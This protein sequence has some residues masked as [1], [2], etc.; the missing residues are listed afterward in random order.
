M[1]DSIQ[2]KIVTPDRVVLREEVERVVAPGSEGDFEVL[3]RHTPFLTSLK[4][5]QIFYSKNGK[6][7]VLSTS[8]GFVEVRMDRMTILAET[9]EWPQEIDRERAEA[10]RRRA[11]RRLE[12]GAPEIDIARAEA[13][14]KRALNRLRVAERLQEQ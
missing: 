13:A 14:L 1:A 2:L 9:S 11:E 8:G 4:I 3:P 6:E 10:A 7:E 5:G 12:E